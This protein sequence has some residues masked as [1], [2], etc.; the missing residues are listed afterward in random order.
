MSQS[1]F[2][3]DR[4]AAQKKSQ[5]LAAHRSVVAAMDELT[6]GIGDISAL[7]DLASEE[8]DESILSDAP[9]MLTA[10]SGNLQRRELLVT[11]QGEYDRG[12]A[13]LSIHPGAGGTESQ[14]WAMMLLRMYTRW[15]EQRGYKVETM[16][17]QEGEEAGIKSATLSVVGPYAYGY[18]KAEK[19]VHRLVR[20][21]P[22]DANARRHTSFASV[23][24]LPDLP[25]DESDVINE[26]E[27]KIDVFRASGAGGQHVNK[28][29]SAIRITHL[30]TGIVVQCQNERSQLNNKAFAMKML[31]GKLLDVREQAQ[32]DKLTRIAG[33]RRDIR[34]GS[35]I[36]SY[37]LHPYSQVKDHRTG[38][39]IGNSGAVL[40]GEIDPF[41]EAFL[42]GVKAKDA[43]KDV[44]EGE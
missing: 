29:N 21:S 2:W 5:Q 24:A 15:A 38:V 9:A 39:A 8:K 3:S 40:D 4:L 11:F 25:E 7:C 12:D 42:K 30:P 6:R 44:E 31:R 33:E 26:E 22:F 10:V 34:F 28:T 43:D 20:I 14:D 19:G 13:L 1:D 23:E 27:L 17:L 41:I 37:V 18:L 36:R 16:D 35:Q 32:T